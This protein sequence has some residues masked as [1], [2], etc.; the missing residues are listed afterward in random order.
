M[1]KINLL[2]ISCAI[3]AWIVLFFILNISYPSLVKMST[4]ASLDTDGFL[5]ENIVY[6]EVT[7]SYWWIFSDRTDHT[8]KLARSSDLVTWETD[9]TFETESFSDSACIRRFGDFWYI[10]YGKQFDDKLNRTNLWMIKSTIIN[11][12]YSDPELILKVG[13]KITDWDYRRVTEP[14]IVFKDG[15]YYLFYMGES[16]DKY[17]KIGYAV[18]PSIDGPF[19]K[20]DNNPVLSGT[21]YFSWNSGKDKAADPYVERLGDVFVIQHTACSV[22]KREW[23]IGLAI[24]KDFVNFYCPNYPVLVADQNNQW[25]SEGVSR[26]GLILIGDKWKI[27]Y[28]GYNLDCHYGGRSGISEID[29]KN[30]VDKMQEDMKRTRE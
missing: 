28:A 1:K 4:G 3:V 11:S 23:N 29:L 16:E 14:D 26:G 5:G 17:E 30:I 13:D 7:L 9:Q 19:I 20:Y 21:A 27:S 10:L 25:F 22:G 2:L 12:G 6:D 15:L 8:I 24:T 18:S